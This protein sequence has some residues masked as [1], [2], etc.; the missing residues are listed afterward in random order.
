M[1]GLSA[2]SIITVIS[3]LLMS[4]PT[5]SAQT[6]ETGTETYGP[7]VSGFFYPRSEETLRKQ[8][9]DLLGKVPKQDIAGRP[10]AII[11]PHAGY[12]YSGGV[13]AYGYNAVKGRDY[14]RVVVIAPSHYGKRFRGVAVLEA[15]RYKTPLGEIEIDTEV[16]REL[17]NNS[18]RFGSNP[19]FGYYSGAYKNEHS[20]E[21]Q[22]P[23]LQ[24]VL[25]EF[26]LVPLV[27]GILM[28]NDYTLVADAI[29]PYLDDSTLVVAS[30]DFTHYGSRFDYV[31]FA[32][33]TE[34]N[35]KVL[36]DGAINEI[37]KK[38]FKGFVDYREKTGIT[39]CGF[40]PIAVLIKLL[41]ADAQG[42]LLAYDTSGRAVKDFSHSV[43]YASIIFTVPTG[44]KTGKAAEP[45][46][47][48][49]RLAPAD[50]R[51]EGNGWEA[52]ENVVLTSDSTQTSDPINDKECKTLLKIAR[53]TLET[54]TQTKKRPEVSGYPLTPR[55]KE[56]S[57]VFVTLK[58]NGELRGCIGH[59]QPM[60]SLWHAV[61]ENTVSSAFKDHRFPPI[62]E[63]ELKDL[64]IEISVLS[65]LKRINGPEEFH[66][67]E[68]G[69]LIKLGGCQAV[70]LP[71][72]ATEQGWDRDQT[73]CNL[74][75]K[76]GLPWYAW[77][78][79]DMEFYV[80]TARVIHEELH[81]RLSSN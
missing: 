50:Y 9:G 80:F 21:T 7:V 33:E 12:D 34:K 53:D 30:S 44:G 78:N 48:T 35:I 6:A 17:V 72:V 43:S 1:Q 18:P 22:L 28:D 55:L 65:P 31:P 74:C 63:E 59:I 69:I 24:T 68:E 56:K 58:K 66:V 20:M 70:F 46:A 10:V 16:C 5:L 14:K 64:D 67:G 29:K 39:V 42:T 36:D 61:M 79:D 25:G 26:K 75:V 81:E 73:L 54:Y 11:S 71:H 32:S 49:S 51:P 8:I 23:F 45:S 3:I 38:D 47:P 76:A 57:G 2:V 4:P 41:P 62:S 77:W 19:L 15:S 60:T 40:T 27:A 13:A 37:L 52:G